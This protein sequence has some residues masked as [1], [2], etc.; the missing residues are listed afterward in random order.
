MCHKT[1]KWR[2]P[3]FIASSSNV[4][5]ECVAEG[6]W[7]PYQVLCY[8]LLAIRW[9]SMVNGWM[10]ARPRIRRADPAVPCFRQGYLFSFRTFLLQY[11]GSLYAL[12]ASHATFLPRFQA[13]FVT[14]RGTRLPLS[15]RSTSLEVLSAIPYLAVMPLTSR[16]CCAS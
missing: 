9:L 1:L 13:P 14:K 12:L 5:P 10:S 11:P 6:V 7:S 8:K 4:A 2:A 3:C 15:F 16:S